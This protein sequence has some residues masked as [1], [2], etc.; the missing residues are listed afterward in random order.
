MPDNGPLPPS[1]NG[2][3]YSPGNLRF[4]Y[5][6][7]VIRLSHPYLWGIPNAV[8]HRL[9]RECV[10]RH[11]LEVGPGNGHFLRRLPQFARPEVLHL[12][13]VHPGP[14]RVAEARLRS[15]ASV[16]THL[17]DAL[18]PWP[19]EPGSLDSVVACMVMHTLPS[20]DVPG[21]RGKA[22][23]VAEAARALRFDGVFGGAAILA[24]GAGVRPTR[25]GPR[26][27]DNYNKR[28]WF[29]NTA[30]TREDLEAVLRGHF[31]RVRLT[32]HGSVAVWR[33]VR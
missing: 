2:R 12:L 7:L 27:M 5:T 24:G 26:A 10:G 33:A 4:A 15:E 16:R 25:Y 18:A 22:A 28:G 32:L 19:V 13:D 3:L 9:Y 17:A 21:I 29:D 1:S 30:D 14:L 23:L 6:P 11:H 31:R 20:E 8:L